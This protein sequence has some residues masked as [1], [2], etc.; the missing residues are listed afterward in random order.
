MKAKVSV[1]TPKITIAN[2]LIAD[3]N[4]YSEGVVTNAEFGIAVRKEKV[5][6]AIEE[7]EYQCFELTINFDGSIEVF[8]IKIQTGTKI[9]NEP[10]EVRY[11]GRGKKN[12]VPIYN[13]FTTLLLNLGVL[14]ESEL[15][16]ITPSNI[17]A[18]IDKAEHLSGSYVRCK[19]GKNEKGYYA[20]DI[21][22][23]ELVDKKQSDTKTI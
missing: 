9:S 21:S 14:V 13:R 19:T 22:T 10:V 8:P 20:V 16:K 5:G 18:I 7:R 12:E 2:T 6:K 1:G 23:L 4:G 17:D 15:D 3:E 11:A